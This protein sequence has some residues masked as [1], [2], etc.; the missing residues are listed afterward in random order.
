MSGINNRIKRGLC[1]ILAFAIVMT[2]FTI[3]VFADSGVYLPVIEVDES[4]KQSGMFYIAY[5]KGEIEEN[6]TAPYLFK[7]Q[8]GGEY[9]PKSAVVLS[10]IDITAKY[11]KDYKIK[12]HNNSFFGERVEGVKENASVLETILENPEE[13][14]E[15]DYTDLLASGEISSKE[16]ADELI[17]EDTQSL[18]EAF[19][20][21]LDGGEAEYEEETAEEEQPESEKNADEVYATEVQSADTLKGAKEMA[22][23]I[24]SDKRAMDGGERTVENQLSGMSMELNSA[25]LRVDFEEGETEKII[26]IIPIDNN[27]GDGDRIFQIFMAGADETSPMSEYTSISVSVCDDE[28]QEDARIS[29]AAD[30]FKPYDD[31]VTVTVN[32]EG[33]INQIVAARLKTEDVSAQSGRDYSLTDTTVTFPYGV[34]ERTIKIPVRD[35]YAAEGAEFKVML[36]EPVGAVLGDI[37]EASC[38]VFG[39]KSF[40]YQ[41]LLAAETEANVQSLIFDESIPG[42]EGY[43]FTA[44]ID[45][46]VTPNGEY[47]NIYSDCGIYDDA[48]SSARFDNGYRYD[49]S[50]YRVEWEK[51]SGKPCFTDTWIDAWNRSTGEWDNVYSSETERW[52]SKTDDIFPKIDNLGPIKIKQRVAGSFIGASPTLIIKSVTPILRPFEITLAASE[53]LKFLNEN[54]VYK[55]NTEITEPGSSNYSPLQ[56]ANR[57]VLFDGSE[58]GSGSVIK[59]SGESITVTTESPYAYIKGLKLIK[60][61]GSK[62]AVVDAKYLNLGG[63]SVSLKLTNNVIREYSDVFTFSDNPNRGKKGAVKVQAILD[64]YDSVI[65]VENDYRGRV[66]V[67]GAKSTEKNYVEDIYDG[68]LYRIKN[69]KSGLYLTSNGEQKNATQQ[70]AQ[71][72]GRDVWTIKKKDGRYRLVADD[73]NYLNIPNNST[74]NGAMVDATPDNGNISKEFYLEYLGDGKFVIST[75]KSDGGSCLSI[76]GDSTA[77]GAKVH[78]WSKNSEHEPMQWQLEMV[79]PEPG[80]YKISNLDGAVLKGSRTSVRF[81]DQDGEDT[82]QLTYD[83]G[84][85]LTADS[86]NGNTLHVSWTNPSNEPYI[87]LQK[88]NGSDAQRFAFANNG[89]GTFGIL[90]K[91]SGYAS[92]LENYD[93]QILVQREY[94]KNS[95]KACWKFEKKYTGQDVEKPYKT[96]T[97]HKGDYIKINQIINDE[98]ANDYTH[99]KV[100]FE[101]DTSNGTVSITFDKGTTSRTIFNAYSKI[102][103][104]PSFDRKD[105]TITVRVPKIYESRFDTSK[106]IFKCPAVEYGTYTDYTVVD[107]DNFTTGNYYEMTAVTKSNSDVAVW[108]QINRENEKYSQETFFFKG[109]AEKEQNII[110]LSAEKAADKLFTL[111]GKTYHAA[112]ALN[113]LSEGEA[114]LPASGANIVIG[115]GQYGIADE[116]G[117]FGTIPA[118]GVIGHY[119]I[120]KLSACG[121][122]EYDVAVLTADKVK[123]FSVTGVSGGETVSAYDVDLGLLKVDAYDRSVPYPASVI[124]TNSNDV[125]N[126]YVVSINDKISKFIVTVANNKKAYTDSDG[127][128]RVEKVVG[129]K[130]LIYDANTNEVKSEITEFTEE[131]SDDGYSTWKASKTFEKGHPAEYSASDKIFVQLTTDRMIGDGKSPVFDDDGNITE[132]VDNEALKQ[133]DYSPVFTGYTLAETNATIPVYH[134]MNIDTDMNFIELPLIGEMTA[135]FNIKSISLSITELPE[136]GQRFSIGYIMRTDAAIEKSGTADNGEKYGVKDLKKA[137]SDVKNFGKKA[138][139]LSSLGMSS[140]GLAPLFGMYVDFKMVKRQFSDGER[141]DFAFDGGGIYLG[142]TGNFRLVQYFL[143]GPV[144]C[145]FGVNGELTVFGTVGMKIGAHDEILTI[146]ELL[147]GGNILDKVRYDSTIQANGLVAAYVG[148]GLCGTLGVR[149]GMQ[150]NAGYIYYPQV[151]NTYPDVDVHGLLLS[152]DIKIWLD[153]FIFSIPVPAFNIY[154]GRFG[155]YAAEDGTSFLNLASSA[156]KSGAEPQL[157]ARNSENAEWVAPMDNGIQLLSTFEENETKTLIENSYDHADPQIVALGENKFMVVFVGDAGDDRDDY[158]RTAVMY[159]VYNGDNATWSKPVI[160]QNDNTADFEPDVVDAGENILVTWTSRKASSSASGNE[161]LKGMEVY[162]V[163][164]NKSTLE[165]GTIERLTDDNYYDSAPVGI[166]DSESGDMIVYYLKSEVDDDAE[167]SAAVSPTLNESVI[168]Y[169]LYDNASGKWMRDSYFENELAYPDDE[170]ILVER[171]GGQRF[172]SSPLADFGSDPDG[173]M[174]DPVIIDFDAISYNGI[175]VYTYTVDEDNNVDTT[176]DRELFV[177]FYDF[178]SH[179]TYVPVRITNDNLADARPQLVRNGDN[180]YL[181]WLQ[182]ETDIRYINITSLVKNGL[183]SDG[184]IKTD[185]NPNDDVYDGYEIEQ[186]VVFFTNDLGENITPTFGSFKPYVDNDGN[187]FVAWLQPVSETD[188]NGSEKSYQE[189]YA[190]AYIKENIDGEATQKGGSWSSGVR[191]TNSQRFNDE[192]AFVTDENGKLMVVNNQYNMNLA[193]ETVT[194]M[195]LVATDFNTVGSVD[196]S[197]VKYADET[198]LEG[199]DNEVTITL[200]N[201]G[202]KA[203]HGYTVNVYEYINGASGG[204]PIYTNTST[205]LLLPSNSVNEVFTW[206]MPDDITANESTALYITVKEEGMPNTCSY[207]SEPVTVEAAYDISNYNIVYEKDGVYAEYSVTNTGNAPAEKPSVDLKIGKLRGDKVVIGF[208]DIYYTGEKYDLFAETFIGELGVDETKTYKSK[209]N[210][211]SKVFATRSYVNAYMEV[212]DGDGEEKSVAKTFTVELKQP[213]DIIINGN[214]GLESITVKKGGSTPLSATYTQAELFENGNIKFETADANIA[215]VDKNGNLV[216]KELGETTLTAT[217]LPY[218]TEK[219]IAVLVEQRVAGGSSSGGSGGKNDGTK[220]DGATTTVKTLADGTVVETTKY[221]DGSTKVVETK[222][223]GTVSISWSNNNGQSKTETD[224]SGN[225]FT[226]VNISDAVAANAESGSVISLPMAPVTAADGGGKTATITVKLPSGVESAKVEI[227]VEN[228]TA[229]TVAIAVNPDGTERVIKTSTVCEN[230]VVVEVGDG[231]T[232]KIANNAKEFADVFDTDWFADAVDFVSARGIFNGT[233]ENCFEPE[234]G[235]TRGMFAQVLYNLADNPVTTRKSTFSDIDGHWAEDA[236][237]WAV[238]NGIVNGYSEDIF[239]VDDEITREQIAVMLYR[240]AAKPETEVKLDGFDDSNEVSDYAKTAM[241]W[242]VESGIITGVTKTTLEPQRIAKRAEVATMLNR[243]LTSR[244]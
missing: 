122:E 56:T 147:T 89:D 168:V 191:L 148:V 70:A 179:K 68:A 71:A 233:S 52:G 161:F 39:E 24:K 69:V 34:K 234:A 103:I 10:M 181:F 18:Y 14:V 135:T 164:I 23:G 16:D 26:E 109:T 55:N 76:A 160:I 95:T 2:G 67:S 185:S 236:V 211:D 198:P 209:I 171:F 237:N 140:W 173:V 114:W 158:N 241:S 19:G 13:I 190:T 154:G 4:V 118:N 21:S 99:S 108:N 117:D 45:G 78:L 225:T 126:G 222:T 27:D 92:G 157:R 170:T 232:I 183:N 184:T 130:L 226:S 137:A 79:S 220:T 231:T 180:T 224:S 100:Q 63:T 195:K 200:K 28:I 206:K 203:A 204:T 163:T 46:S 40:E 51:K 36:Q 201:S 192:F 229:G 219:N 33:A 61:D 127:V 1:F 174:D 139:E 210:A 243:A 104:Y 202:L 49:Y 11:G 93:R 29:F 152:A 213:Q 132:Y 172:L 169:M 105:N 9:L 162:A 176:G 197:A 110:Y 58:N 62:S 216:G 42:N 96:Y 101:T 193:N 17:L 131:S 167:F 156:A 115:S 30:S 189:V 80:L 72:D 50:G 196:V 35:N 57:T 111:S 199:S 221:D 166:Y 175:G 188:E 88:D 82:W 113:G 107:T 98:Y 228:I 5:D 41:L 145:Y 53:P 38:S 182:N 230:G 136:G 25:R 106:G 129:V 125:Q 239:G 223:D 242:A 74:S 124:A 123:N 84:V 31:F 138:K 43:A 235:M 153:A 32:R 73:G 87:C 15:N 134:E 141:T 187:L 142:I 194:D 37:T 207:I 12:I 83:N 22:T 205:E 128:E 146:D 48:T 81:N 143:V 133:T 102:H 119:V 116:N 90:T 159:T 120:Y 244:T 97:C 227:P 85:K 8:R 144:P 7:V 151:K 44:S 59:F 86:G 155:Y 66:E 3:P 214:E 238:E 65:E 94:N 177:Q 54:G 240:Y 6:S 178:A 215:Y 20:V 47:L 186:S 121:R 149:G 77:E 64:Y 112:K 212:Q 75:A 91:L 218:G 60:S 208:N 217:V 150:I 165:M